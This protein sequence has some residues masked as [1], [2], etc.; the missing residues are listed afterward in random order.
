MSF[1]NIIENGVGKVKAAD[2]LGGSVRI[3]FRQ[4][5]TGQIVSPRARVAGKP[6][7]EEQEHIS[8][9]VPPRSRTQHSLGQAMDLQLL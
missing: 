3:A 9:Y 1:D 2:C 4:I 8:E 5:R 7:P 6:G